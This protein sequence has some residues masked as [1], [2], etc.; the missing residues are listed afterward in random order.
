MGRPENYGATENFQDE[1]FVESRIGPDLLSG[2]READQPR[3]PRLEY[4]LI[5]FY[6]ISLSAI[7]YKIRFFSAKLS[8]LV[9]SIQT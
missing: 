5:T 9:D 7:Y 2:L 1:K 6:R 3:K 4:M 8:K